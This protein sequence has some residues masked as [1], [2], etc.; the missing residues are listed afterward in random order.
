MKPL[1]I[2]LIGT[3]GVPANYGGFETCVEEIGQRLAAK[4]H[5]VVVYCRKSYYEDATPTYKGMK[6]VLLPNLKKKSLDTFSHT[7]LSALHALFQ[8]YDVHMVFN[9]ANAPFVLPLRLLGKKIAINTDGLEWQRSKWGFLG[10]SYYKF[11]EKFSCFMANRLVSDSKGIQDYYLARHGTESTEIAYGAYIQGSD[12]NKHL[13]RLGLE[14][15]GYFLQITRFEPENHPLMTI[16]AFKKLETDKKLVLVGGNPYPSQYLESIES[17]TGGNIMLP[18]YI[19]DKDVLRELW[20]R[21]HA[22]VH[23]NSVGG[24]NPALLQTMASGCFTLAYDVPFNRDVLADC[25]RFYSDA[26]SLAEMMRWSL[27]DT[28]KLDEYKAKSQERIRLHYDWDMIT[29]KYEALFQELAGSVH[30]WKFRPG[31]L[32]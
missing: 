6:R 12:T 25:G 29:D 22:Y 2:A 14:P 20:C 9:A 4:G 1:K 30:P 16:E 32:F 23:G 18:G 3:R 27:E 24:T 17:Q 11:A 26:D 8:G 13:K 21:C 7:T 10:R 31:S 15:G 28:D 19:Y 5:H